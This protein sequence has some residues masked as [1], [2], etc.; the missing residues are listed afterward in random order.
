[1]T[2]EE[3]DRVMATLTPSDLKVLR[4]FGAPVPFVAGENFEITPE[5]LAKIQALAIR[6]LNHPSRRKRR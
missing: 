6:K 4:R 1:M 5:R 2:K 3:H